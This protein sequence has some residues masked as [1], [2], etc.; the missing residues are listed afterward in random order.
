MV[1]GRSAGRRG[2]RVRQTPHRDREAALELL[3]RLGRLARASLVWQ[4]T[5]EVRQVLA[6]RQLQDC[7]SKP[8]P[9]RERNQSRIYP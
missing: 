7:S 9:G 8:I 6:R 2:G 3:G 4:G 5:F 1:G